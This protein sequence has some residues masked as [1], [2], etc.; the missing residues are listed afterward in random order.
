MWLFLTFFAFLLLG[1]SLVLFSRSPKP[2][3]GGLLAWAMLLCGICLTMAVVTF[4]SPPAHAGTLGLHVGSQHFPNRPRLANANP[5]LY[6]KADNGV[7]VGAFRNSLSRSSVYLAYT[8]NVWGPLDL[9]VGAI[10]G[11]R[12]RNGYGFNNAHLAPLI[13][14][15]V[16]LPRLGGVTP[17]LTFIPPMKNVTAVVHLSLEREF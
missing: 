15:S 16:R 8:A 14:P 1:W 10:S 7:T 11:Y 3:H 13:A 12:L 2:W 17:R 4:V 9:T 5:G 6:Y